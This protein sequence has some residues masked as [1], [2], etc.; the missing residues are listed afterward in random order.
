MVATSILAGS[1]AAA[2]DSQE[3]ARG[4]VA[5]LDWERIVQLVALAILIIAIIVL[6]ILW[7]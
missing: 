7:L 2:I 5:G 1:R 6:V 3:A 4:A